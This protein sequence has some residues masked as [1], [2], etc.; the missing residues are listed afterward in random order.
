MSDPVFA[1][2]LI[3]HP[4]SG[5]S[6][7]STHVRSATVGSPAAAATMAVSSND[8]EL[9]LAIQHADRC[10]DLNPYVVAVTIDI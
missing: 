2:P 3:P 8:P 5:D 7:M 9:L 1:C 6:V 10:Q 4:P